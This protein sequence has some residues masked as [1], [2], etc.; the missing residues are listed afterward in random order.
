M[1]ADLV[2]V[3]AASRDDTEPIG[4]AERQHR[5]PDRQQHDQEQHERHG[6]TPEPVAGRVAVDAPRRGEREQQRGAGERL[7][8]EHE[9]GGGRC[10]HRHAERSQRASRTR[11]TTPA[12]AVGTASGFVRSS[13]SATYCGRDSSVALPRRVQEEV[14]ARPVVPRLPEEVRHDQGAGDRD[15]QREA[16]RAKEVA[17]PDEERRHQRDEHDRERYF[18]SSPI[19]AASPRKARSRGRARAGARARARAIVATWSNDT[20]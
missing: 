5:Q 10:D 2:L 7:A 9:V 15:G 20:G 12:T 11:P 1:P 6:E 14:H 13:R 3:V 18:V 8:A 4:G 19:P 17:A 16:R